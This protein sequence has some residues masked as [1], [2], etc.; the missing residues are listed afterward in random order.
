MAVKLSVIIPVYNIRKEYLEKCVGSV[1]GQDLQE[2]E[3]ILVNDGSSLA[4]CDEVC[5]LA[6]Q[7]DARVIYIHKKNEGVSVARNS[8]IEKASGEYLMFVDADD[9]LED[10]ICGKAYRYAREK[11]ADLLLFGYRTNYTNREVTRMLSQE[12]VQRLSPSLL[13][14]NVL[15]RTGVFGAVDIGTPWAKLIRRQMVM[16]N[17][18]RYIRGLTKGQDT[19]FSLYLFDACKKIEYLNA[20]G[21][22]YRVSETSVSKKYNPE[23]VAVM[24]NTLK[25][26]DRFVK[27]HK[28]SDRFQ[29][30]V[31]NKYVAVVLGEYLPLYYF[32]KKNKKRFWEIRREVVKLLQR[33]P[34]CTY[35]RDVKLRGLVGGLK[36]FFLKRKA[37]LPLYI[38]IKG[39]QGLRN[40][41]IHKFE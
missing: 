2:M 12:A 18:L 7:K 5:A 38:L 22:H 1:T 14:L 29:Q 19:V 6:A 24:E 36:G 13:Q 3:I 30:A 37:V 4:S 20:V 11:D 33:E 26:Y 34:Y 40:I 8:G 35:I 28:K 10:G 21:Y 17:N 9:W 41:I 23:I 32:H 25:E 15:R 27:E 39:E 16:E 31:K